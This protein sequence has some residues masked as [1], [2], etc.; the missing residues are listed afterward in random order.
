MD[1]MRDGEL[2]PTDLLRPVTSPQN[3]E[4]HKCPEEQESIASSN[5]KFLL[6][7]QSLSDMFGQCELLLWRV[8][9]ANTVVMF[10]VQW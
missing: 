7:E 8:S 1:A 4:L 2:D 5:L 6:F 10:T 9:N 3:P